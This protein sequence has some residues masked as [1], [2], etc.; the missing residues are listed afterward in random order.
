MVDTR[1]MGEAQQWEGQGGGEGGET[2]DGFEPNRGNPRKPQINNAKPFCDGANF[3]VG[4][5]RFLK[6]E[7]G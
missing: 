4:G 1:E 5:I 3:T 7:R 6:F 2:G